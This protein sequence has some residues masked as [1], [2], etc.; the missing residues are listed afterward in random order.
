MPPSSFPAGLRPRR[1]SQFPFHPKTTLQISSLSSLSPSDRE[2]LRNRNG[3]ASPSGRFA[4]S[5]PL[6]SASPPL[7]SGAR[8]TLTG[9][10]MATAR[11]GTRKHRK[12]KG[13][14]GNCEVFFF[15][16]LI[17]ARLEEARQEQGLL[18]WI[19]RSMQWLM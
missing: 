15:Q 3:H 2:G 14:N 11:A 6:L 19:M 5:C 7:R 13:W 18:G 4:L 16:A 12:V 1:T 17:A 9:V 10:R 8:P